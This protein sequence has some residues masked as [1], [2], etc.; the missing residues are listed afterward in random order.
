MGE[1]SKVKESGYVDVRRISK[2][3]VESDYDKG[4]ERRRK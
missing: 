3:K 2:S 1:A 4:M